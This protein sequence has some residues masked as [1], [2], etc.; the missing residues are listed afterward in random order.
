MEKM[1]K[2][3][4]DNWSYGNYHR[5]GYKRDM[6][7]TFFQYVD[8]QAIYN[9]GM[10]TFTLKDRLA[11]RL[12]ANDLISAET[13]RGYYG[14]ILRFMAQMQ[15]FDTWPIEQI[16]GQIRQIRRQVLGVEVLE[17]DR[18]QQREKDCEFTLQDGIDQ[19]AKKEALLREKDTLIVALCQ[20]EL[21]LLMK[22]DVENALEL[23][24]KVYVLISEEQ[25]AGLPTREEIQ[26]RMGDLV[27]S[28][29]YHAI[30]SRSFS[31]KEGAAAAMNTPP[32][33]SDFSYSV[34]A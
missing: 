31:L 9:V 19:R 4:D 23:G 34:T 29:L 32:S 15:T 5:I 27:I 10:G 18:R 17:K 14:M 28:R 6:L 21:F 26:D 7:Y 12:A 20:P 24:H 22:R 1:L 8:F 13:L 3:T 33:L 16:Y 25:A 11:E 30:S 2:L